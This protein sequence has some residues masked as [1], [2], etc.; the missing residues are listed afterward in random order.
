VNAIDPVQRS[1]GTAMRTPTRFRAAWAGAGLIAVLAAL[2][3]CA[4]SPTIN[5]ADGVANA[6]GSATPGVPPEPGP[7]S[8][9]PSTPPGQPQPVPAPNPPL[10]AGMT[11]VDGFTV[12]VRCPVMTEAGCPPTPVTARITVTDPAGAAVASATSDKNGHFRIALRPGV[13]TLF[14]RPISGAF[15]RPTSAKLTVIAGRMMTVRLTMD[16]GIR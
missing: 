6:S 14:A 13:Y 15:P 10:P 3:A 5:S 7:T 8:A 12:T 9:A 16:S 2:P 4:V 1:E 11:G